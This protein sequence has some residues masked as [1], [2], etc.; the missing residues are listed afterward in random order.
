MP[1][2]PG[3]PTA[4]GLLFGNQQRGNGQ[5][6]GRI[7]QIGIGRSC[8]LYETNVD[9]LRRPLAKTL[10]PLGRNLHRHEPNCIGKREYDVVG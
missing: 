10:N 8:F 9:M 4:S 2:T 1:S 3:A 6:R 5:M 7:E